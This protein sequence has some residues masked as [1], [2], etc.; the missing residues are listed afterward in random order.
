M[1]SVP[2]ARNKWSHK[3]CVYDMG[4]FNLAYELRR[5]SSSV[6]QKK[7]ALQKDRT[8]RRCCELLMSSW[9]IL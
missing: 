7:L 1:E 2:S 3:M 6:G 8:I 9:K 4:I 5:Q